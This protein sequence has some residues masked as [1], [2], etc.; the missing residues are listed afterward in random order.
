MRACLHRFF[1]LMACLAV[2][3]AL[4]PGSALAL[5]RGR[6]DGAC[7]RAGAPDYRMLCAVG[8]GAPREFSSEVRAAAREGESLAKVPEGAGKVNAAKILPVAAQRG[9]DRS[10]EQWMRSPDSAPA[11]PGLW[12][13]LAAGFLGICALARPRIFAS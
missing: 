10:A 5:E 9:N 1:G 6:L 13:L 12:A 8:G 3:A 4:G 2:A 7:N 11:E